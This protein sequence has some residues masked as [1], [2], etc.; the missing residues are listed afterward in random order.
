LTLQT[1]LDIKDALRL[2]TGI[3]EVKVGVKPSFERSRITR[4]IKHLFDCVTKFSSKMM[5]CFEH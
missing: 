1:I 3:V 2:K 5:A 4:M